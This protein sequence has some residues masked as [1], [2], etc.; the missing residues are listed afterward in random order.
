MFDLNDRHLGTIF[1][2]ICRTSKY[3]N[4]NFYVKIYFL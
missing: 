3:T 4:G 1:F 2:L